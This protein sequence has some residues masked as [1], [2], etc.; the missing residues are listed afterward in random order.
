M[1][2]IRL[3]LSVWGLTLS[4]PSILAV[5]FD[6]TLP[7]VFGI[8]RCV[9][10]GIYCDW[11]ETEPLPLLTNI[12]PSLLHFN[13]PVHHKHNDSGGDGK[14]V[15]HAIQTIEE[16][17]LHA[18]K[19]EVNIMFPHEYHRQHEQQLPREGNKAQIVKGKKN[20]TTVYPVQ[21]LHIRFEKEGHTFPYDL[22]GT[23]EREKHEHHIAHAVHEVEKAVVHTI[24]QEVGVLFPHPHPEP[25]KQRTIKATR[26]ANNMANKP[27]ATKQN[28]Q[29]HHDYLSLQEFLEFTD[30]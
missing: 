3:F 20:K 13:L 9:V 29:E 15:I 11:D 23:L 7:P 10:T 4:I 28:E 22:Q 5:P 17:F 8:P 24:E 26:P 6:T 1:R 2:R 30:E 14:A 21:G 27:K 18:L 19:D 16:T 25:R 12:Q